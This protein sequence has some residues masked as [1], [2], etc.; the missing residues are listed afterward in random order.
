MARKMILTDM[1]GRDP[2]EAILREREE[3][4]DSLICL[5]TMASQESLEQ[6]K[7]PVFPQFSYPE[8]MNIAIWTLNHVW[9]VV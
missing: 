8:I 9:K 7:E 6:S 4:L 5:G 3:G 2:T 1:H